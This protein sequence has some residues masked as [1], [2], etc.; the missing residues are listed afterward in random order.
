MPS[1]YW[2]VSILFLVLT[3]CPSQD[4]DLVVDCGM[5]QGVYGRQWYECTYR[6]MSCGGTIYGQTALV[7]IDARMLDA[8]GGEPIFALADQLGRER[9]CAE[10]SFAPRD[11]DCRQVEGP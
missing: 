2:L 1:N 8:V 10:D 4:Y 11:L 3:G 5:P 9:G 7:C 6:V